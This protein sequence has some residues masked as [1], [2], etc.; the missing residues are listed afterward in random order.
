MALLPQYLTHQMGVITNRAT[1]TGDRKGTSSSGSQAIW[2]RRT[3]PDM[4]TLL[5]LVCLSLGFTDEINSLLCEKLA[6]IQSSSASLHKAQPDFCHC[7]GEPNICPKHNP[8][9]P[10]TGCSAGKTTQNFTFPIVVYSVEVPSAQ[11]WLWLL[12]ELY[13]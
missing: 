13:T 8:C 5:G 11:S 12:Y 1:G 10:Q 9:Q 4:E 2:E 7:P 6:L 3:V